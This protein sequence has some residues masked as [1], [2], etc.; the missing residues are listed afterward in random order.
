MAL[1]R[2]DPTYPGMYFMN[3]KLTKYSHGK[4]RGWLVCDLVWFELTV[5]RQVYRK[6]NKQ[7]WVQD[8]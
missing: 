4:L 6:V 7:D 5:S 2:R 3:L 8:M 1:S